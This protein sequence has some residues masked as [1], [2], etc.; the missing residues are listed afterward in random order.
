MV[1]E[2]DIWHQKLGHLNYRAMK[3]LIKADDVRGLP[4]LT[5]KTESI[6]GACQAGKQMRTSHKAQPF[7]STKH[8]LELIHMDL[9][10]PTQP[11]SFGE[12]S[13]YFYKT[14][15]QNKI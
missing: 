8:C 14:I 3:K 4:K 11:E 12:F 9:I 2:P 6:C 7:I 1:S 5:T 13:I 15:R 10:G